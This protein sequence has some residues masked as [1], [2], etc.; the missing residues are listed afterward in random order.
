MPLFKRQTSGSVVCASCG[1]LVGVRDDRCFNCGR[2][3]PGLW[4]FAPLLRSLGNDLGFVQLVI[5]VCGALY[6]VE[7]LMSGRDLI[8]VGGGFSFLVPSS[9]S[10]ILLGASGAVPVFLAGRWWTIFSASW[11]HGS[12]LHIVFNMMWVRDLGPATADVVGP[13]RTVV[14]YTVSGACGFLLSSFAGYYLR[15]PI[16][17]L[18]G[19]PYTMG[20]SAS[21]FGL[22]GALWHYGRM[23]GSS[24]IRGQAGYYAAVLFLMGLV[25]PGVDNYAHAGGF[26]GGYATSAFFNP[27][28]RERGDHLLI[29]MAC[30]AATLLAI[31]FSVLHGLG[32]L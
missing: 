30:L 32:I 19:A 27:L 16:P 31:A 10:I 13:S 14:I 7:L 24:Y 2:R 1:S 12:L 17:L 4:G 28:T 11:L 3:N 25:M 18:N 6:I 20:A 5:W 22:L 8:V 29:A 26:L 23:S 9:T 21:I 15:I